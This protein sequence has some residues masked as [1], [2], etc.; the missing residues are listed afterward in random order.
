MPFAIRIMST[1]TSIFTNSITDVL[2]L[3]LTTKPEIQL[4]PSLSYCNGTTNSN[5]QI[6]TNGKKRYIYKYYN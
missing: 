5:Y 6:H 1:T 2:A 4:S 3:I